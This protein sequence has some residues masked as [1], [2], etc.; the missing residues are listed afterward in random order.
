[1]T[2]CIIRV[3]EPPTA[4]SERQKDILAAEII[5]VNSPLNPLAAHIAVFVWYSVI[6]CIVVHEDHIS[7][8]LQQKSPHGHS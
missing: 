5:G 8:V 6:I 2:A 1:M 4:I 7:A 3:C